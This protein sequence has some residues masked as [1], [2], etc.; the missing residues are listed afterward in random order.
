MCK[1]GF[2][3]LTTV[4]QS[5]DVKPEYLFSVCCL[6]HMSVTD[7]AIKHAICGQW[8]TTDAALSCETCDHQSY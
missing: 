7:T 4:K 6:P 8:F 2:A 5:D 3:F 1:Q